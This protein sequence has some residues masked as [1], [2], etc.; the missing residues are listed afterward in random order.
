M[1]TAEK[2]TATAKKSTGASPAAK[3]K[4]TA[5]KT[6]AASKGAVKAKPSAAD[7]L[8][9][10]FNDSLKDIYWAEKALVKA[11]PKMAKN[12][13]SENLIAAI[14]DHLA[15]TEKQVTRLEQVFKSVGEKAAAKKCDAMEGLIK[16]GESIMEETEKGPVRDAGIIAASQKIEHYEIATYGT[17]AAFASTLGEDD[18][19]LLLEKT[20]AEEKEADT[21]LTEAAYNTINF[22][23]NAADEK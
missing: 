6:T 9:E 20:L 8:R 5:A 23:A 18:A 12:A 13:T 1:K 19:V 3:S 15:V 10:L 17:L 14:N 21:L 11:L 7:G 16:E 2:N 22:D 4:T